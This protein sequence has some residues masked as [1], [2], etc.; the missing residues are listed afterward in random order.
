MADQRDGGIAWTDET[1]NPIRGC[2]KVSAGCAHC[3]AETMA[4]RFCGDGQPYAGLIEGG[5]WSGKV[6]MVPEHLKDPLRWRRPRRVFVNSMS[7]LFHESLSFQDIASIFGVMAAAPE[8]TFQVLTKRAKRMAEFFAWLKQEG[9]AIHPFEKGRTTERMV[10]LG[11]AFDWVNALERGG[12]WPL[13]NVWLG[14]SVENQTAAD[15][16][17]PILLQVPAAVRWISMEP[18]LGPVDLTMIQHG[19][20]VFDALG[21]GGFHETSFEPLPAPARLDWVV[22]GGE[23]GPKAR[24]MHP[25]WVQRLRD[26]CATAHVPFLMKQWGEWGPL[27]HPFDY[28]TNS[29]GCQ[30]IGDSGRLHGRPWPGWKSQKP[31]AEVVIRHGRAKAGRVLDG[32]IH[33]AFPKV[34]G[35]F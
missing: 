29:D 31:G 25:G 7:D 35:G 28:V 6:R 26:Q 34:S 20:H 8:H 2:S 11:Q 23:R 5:R 17:I 13:P 10:V 21:G 18:L 15:E 27:Q 33:D 14:V 19:A 30:I 9:D 12:P 22:V 16:R 24:P 3:Y 4:A 1:W 32:R